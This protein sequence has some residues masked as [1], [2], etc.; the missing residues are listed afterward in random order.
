MIEIEK[1][2]LVLPGKWPKGSTQIQIDQGYMVRED[3]MVIRVRRKNEQ[4]YLSVKAKIDVY[5]SY[6]FEYPI[7]ESDA[8]VMLEHLCTGG[9]VRKT[10]HEVRHE[11]M[12][13]EIDEFH[14]DNRGLVVAEIELPEQDTDFNLP[15]WI[16]EEV[17]HDSRYRNASLAALPYTHW[18]E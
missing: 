7:P 3:G 5:S 2:F 1:K 10:R 12:L 6:D 8:Q 13:W 17:T 11:D 16:G 18:Q 15:S 14:G 9:I 4:C